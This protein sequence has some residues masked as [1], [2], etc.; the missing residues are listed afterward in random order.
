MRNQFGGGYATDLTFRMPLS[1]RTRSRICIPEHPG[2]IYIVFEAM[3]W[4]TLV[5]NLNGIYTNNPT[6]DPWKRCDRDYGLHLSIALNVDTPKQMEERLFSQARILSRAKGGALMQEGRQILEVRS[7]RSDENMRLFVET[8]S[9]LQT[10]LRSNYYT[11]L[12][13]GH[14]FEAQAKRMR[15]SV[16]RESSFA[17][18]LD[19]MGRISNGSKSFCFVPIASANE[20]LVT[21]FDAAVPTIKPSTVYPASSRKRRR[22]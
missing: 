14:R 15:H 17:N 16:V 2:A 7:V 13:N 20:K 3:P 19:T 12:S 8:I 9:R 11:P 5:R 18:I 21:Q 6:P 4:S 22:N 10:I 1:H